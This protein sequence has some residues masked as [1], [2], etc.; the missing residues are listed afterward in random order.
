MAARRRQQRDALL[1]REG[2]AEL[3]RQ[4]APTRGALVGDVQ[5]VGVCPEL[6]KAGVG[7]RLGAQEVAIRALLDPTD[8]SPQTGAYTRSLF[9]ST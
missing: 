3:R 5:P 4:R 7:A 1:N 6:G 9:S 8:R 2:A